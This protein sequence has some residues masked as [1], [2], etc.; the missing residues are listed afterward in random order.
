MAQHAQR[1]FKR[2]K[3]P[4]ASEIDPDQLAK[5]GLNQLYMEQLSPLT[6]WLRSF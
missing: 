1:E 3:S 6:P 2:Y 5:L 4:W